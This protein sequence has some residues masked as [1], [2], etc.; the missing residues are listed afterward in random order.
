MGRKSSPVAAAPHLHL[1]AD[2]NEHDAGQPDG[3]V[4]VELVGIPAAQAG[5]GEGESER[6]RLVGQSGRRTGPGQTHA[7]PVRDPPIM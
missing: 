4:L 1:D 7:S 3:L 5:R 6:R 2:D